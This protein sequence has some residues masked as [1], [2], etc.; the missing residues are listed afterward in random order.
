MR[1]WTTIGAVVAVLAVAGCGWTQDDFDA[2]RS[3]GNELETTLT[4]ANAPTLTDH[5]IPGTV[6]A[7]VGNTLIT[8]QGQDV[9]AFD[10]STC[11]RADNGPCTPLWSRTGSQWGGS[12]GSHLVFR[13]FGDTTFEVT[14]ANE[15]LLWTG[16]AEGTSLGSGGEG[17]VRLGHVA[18]SGGHLIVAAEEYDGH[19]G[20][21]EIVNVFPAAGCG[22][23]SCAPSRTF[24]HQTWDAWS[25][26]GDTLFLLDEFAQ[27]LVARSMTSGATLWSTSEKFVTGTPIRIRAGRVFVFR[28]A[29]NTG[30]AVYDLAGKQGCSGNPVVCSPERLLT[31]PGPAL[32]ALSDRIG[33]GT[34]QTGSG[35]TVDR[36][37]TLFAPDGA[38]CT[39][40]CG[41]VAT[42]APV[43]TWSTQGFLD[44]AVTANLVVTVWIPPAFT[45]RTFHLLAYDARLSSHCS[46][47]PKLC[48]PV[49][50]VPFPIGNSAYAD[51]PIVAGGRVYVTVPG[52]YPADPVTHVLSLPGDAG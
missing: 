23:P 4:I 32:I 44:A 10:R 49:A 37:L 52:V 39:S 2:G 31:A 17:F 48:R 45:N 24:T 19:G 6:V 33:A 36:S 12:D 50:D 20:T 14:D 26:G 8:Q 25:A 16:T 28:T 41:P 22:T 34:T 43:T 3:R 42:T 38:G 5:T 47:A 13:G 35:G 27:P 51:A 30:T 9:V 29:P 46:G 40:P 7:L 21:G 15:N 18:F 1:R 11:P